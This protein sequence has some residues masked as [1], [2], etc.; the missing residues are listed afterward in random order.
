MKHLTV[1]KADS[2]DESIYVVDHTNG[3]IS[4]NNPFNLQSWVDKD[5]AEMDERKTIWLKFNKKLPQCAV[6]KVKAA[7]WTIAYK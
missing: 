4:I 6:S 5:W 3:N 1:N 2:M 7:N